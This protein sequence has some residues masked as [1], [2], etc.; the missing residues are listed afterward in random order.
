MGKSH[1]APQSPQ[2]VSL[3]KCLGPGLYRASSMVAALFPVDTRILVMAQRGPRDVKTRA[4]KLV[5][6]QDP[7]PLDPLDPLVRPPPHVEPST[8]SAEAGRRSQNPFYPPL[9]EG[10]NPPDSVT[11]PSHTR[12]GTPYGPSEVSSVGT[13]STP[14]LP[15]PKTEQGHFVC[16]PF[17]NQGFI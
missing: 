8:S 14:P 15:L 5:L 16:V 13:S 9:P 4:P 17:S 3:Y 10:E 7:D 2:P 11:S 1:W 6:S 12:T